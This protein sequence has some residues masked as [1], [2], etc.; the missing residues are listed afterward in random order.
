MKTS[1]GDAEAKEVD[2]TVAH[3]EG[4]TFEKRSVNEKFVTGYEVFR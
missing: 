1:G 2:Q 3:P 4:T